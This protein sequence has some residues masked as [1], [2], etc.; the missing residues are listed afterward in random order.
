MFTNIALTAFIF[1]LISAVSLP[2]GA[3]TITFWKPKEKVIAALMSF[4]GGAL[5]AALTIDLVASEIKTGYFYPLAAGC[6]LGGILFVL[7]NR[8]VN[9]KGGFLRKSS[10][11][12]NYLK[13]IKLKEYKELFKKLSYVNLFRNLPPEEI[14][15]L[16]PH[17]TSRQY[18]KGTT[19]IHQGDPGDSLFI[20][21][22]GSVDVIDSVKNKYIAT[23]T[24]N[25]VVGEMALI[26]GEKRSSSVIAKTNTKVWTILK[27]NF[28]NVLNV[29]SKMAK[30]FKDIVEERINYLKKEEIISHDTAEQWV[31]KASKHVDSKITIPTDEEIKEAVS[32]HGGAPLAI[33]LGILLD[34]IPESLVIGASLIHSSISLSLIAG[35][36]LSNYP[37]ALSSSVGMKKQGYS[38]IKIFTMWS[39][40]M[41]ITGFGAF[42][43]NIFFMNAPHWL[44]ALIE[45]MAAGAML[46]MIAETMLPEAY[47]KGGTITG[48]STLL[49]F[50]AALF[51][52]TLETV[53]H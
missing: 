17:I 3:A 36:F 12:I 32:E 39:S 23:L 4:G 46:T 41:I 28:D 52:K 43:G 50:L 40:L 10:T 31:K 38:F 35:L 21:E 51:F 22:N 30:A 24:K 18:K 5:L 45:G 25:D 20:I 13:K 47:V 49:G 44:F 19:I 26:T 53:G 37:E 1:G 15:S 8:T 11:T 14:Q 2:L 33:W 7:L 29:S 6:I 9:N 48:F 34:G 42:F 16:L 27:E